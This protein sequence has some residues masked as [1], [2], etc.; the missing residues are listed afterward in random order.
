MVM[1]IKLIDVVV[2]VVVVVDTSRF[3]TNSNSEIAQRFRSLQTSKPA[4]FACE[5]FWANILRSIS[6]VREN[7]YNSTEKLISKLLV[8]KRL[9]AG[10]A[11]D[12]FLPNSLKTLCRL[13]RTFLDL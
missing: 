6:Q 9:C 8:P 4:Q 2:V 5:K 11:N 1:Q 10:A 7:I 13:S 3:H 12:G